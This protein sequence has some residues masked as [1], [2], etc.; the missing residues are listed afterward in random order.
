[1]VIRGLEVDVGISSFYGADK[2]SREA[3]RDMGVDV[4]TGSNP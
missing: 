4:F 3:C 1:L 2:G